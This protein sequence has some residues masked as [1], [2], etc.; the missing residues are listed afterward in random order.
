MECILQE[1]QLWNDFNHLQ[2]EMIV[3]P[4]GRQMFPSPKFEVNGLEMSRFLVAKNII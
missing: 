1:S 3:S 4:K 2:N